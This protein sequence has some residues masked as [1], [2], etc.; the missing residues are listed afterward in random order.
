MLKFLTVLLVVTKQQQLTN[1]QCAIAFDDADKLPDKQLILVPGQSIENLRKHDKIRWTNK[2]SSIIVRQG[3][4]FSGFNKPS[5][6]S[7][8]GD[9]TANHEMGKREDNKI[10]S[11]KCICDDDDDTD[12]DND[13]E[14]GNDDDEATNGS[15]TCG[16][17]YF[18]ENSSAGCR[19]PKCN[20]ASMDMIDSWTSTTS[21][22]LSGF[23][24][25][26]KVPR[27]EYDGNGWSVVLRFNVAAEN[28]QANFQV[29]N[30]DFFNVYRKK[31]AVEILIH[32]TRRS[33]RDGT[34]AHAFVIVAERLTS[35]A[36]PDIFFWPQREQNHACFNRAMTGR[37]TAFDR[38]LA[39]SEKVSKN[40]EIG[41]LTIRRSGKMKMRQ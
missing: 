14:N 35:T 27:G 12:N 32:Q 19:N 34:D 28:F 2:I 18:G 5:F 33:H 31:D 1:E 9:W 7:K 40:T 11:I 22:M 15:N 6:G 3:C 20:V 41:M 17:R 24:A 26:V 36:K 30:A 37:S 25:N 21:H 4:T 38:A 39:S 29:W 16:A 8:L 13:N 10:S 23:V